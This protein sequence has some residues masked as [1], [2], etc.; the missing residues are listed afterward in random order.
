[1]F[2]PRSAPTSR[3]SARPAAR[4][5]TALL[6]A[7]AFGL[8]AIA[9]AA[10]AADDEYPLTPSPP[11]AAVYFVNLNDGDTVS[12]PVK[13][14]FGLSGMG[15]A[16]AGIEQEATGHHHLFLNRAPLN[17]A[18]VGEIIPGDEEH[19]H[20]GGGQTEAVLD[21]EPGAYTMQLVLGDA[22]HIPHEPPVASDVITIT[23]Q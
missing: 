1:M 9:P 22:A 4:G 16:P 21:L 10:A 19:I 15:I 2:L 18:D 3:S 17:E 23:V 20:F 8:V 11:G 13:V 12:A 7:L 5:S 6:G 14:V